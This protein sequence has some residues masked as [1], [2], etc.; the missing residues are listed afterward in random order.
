[1]R[2]LRRIVSPGSS[3]AVGAVPIVAVAPASSDVDS[4]SVRSSPCEGETMI[5]ADSEIRYNVQVR[6]RYGTVLQVTMRY[7]VKT[8]MNKNTV[9]T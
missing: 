1:M 4:H 7:N 5:D 8:T 6:G 2:I 9:F 3:F